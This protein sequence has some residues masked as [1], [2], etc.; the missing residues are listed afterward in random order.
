MGR[1]A[2][3]LVA[4]FSTVSSLSLA[5][6]RFPEPS[7]DKESLAR[8][9][10]HEAEILIYVMPAARTV[11]EQGM[12]VGWEKSAAPELNHEDYFFFW[13]YNSKRQGSGSVTIGHFA[14]DKRNAEV[15]DFM[16]GERVS[17]VELGGVQRILR[18]AHQ[19]KLPDPRERMNP[20]FWLERPPKK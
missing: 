6:L 1:A 7:R 2:W 13:V 11:R 18:R 9:T 19:V 12:D 4:I 14:V 16:T 20:N 17:S 15:W 3:K 10:F 8:I 5:A